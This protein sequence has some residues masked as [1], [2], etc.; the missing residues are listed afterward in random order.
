M[1]KITFALC[2]ISAALLVLAATASFAASEGE[3]TVKAQIEKAGF[4]KPRRI[5]VMA[6]A[7]AYSGIEFEQFLKAYETRLTFT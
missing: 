1:K 3:T 2:A 5:G 7:R 6:G 4:N